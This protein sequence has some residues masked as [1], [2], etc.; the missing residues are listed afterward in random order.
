VTSW[1][2][3]QLRARLTRHRF[4]ETQSQ[5]PKS[6]TDQNNKSL[7]SSQALSNTVWAFSKLGEDEEALLDAVA[8]ASVPQLP[9]FNAQNLANLVREF[10]LFF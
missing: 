6:Q 10:T 7:L 5:L 3:H 4:F 8:A 9:E 2:R 1:R